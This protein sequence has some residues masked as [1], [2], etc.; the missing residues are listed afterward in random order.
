MIAHPYKMKNNMIAPKF[1]SSIN[2]FIPKA[3]INKELAIAGIKC[4][5]TSIIQLLIQ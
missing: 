5:T 1:P 2:A 3:K 4:F